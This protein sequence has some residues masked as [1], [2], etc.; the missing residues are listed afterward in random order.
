MALRWEGKRARTA[1]RARP[2]HLLLRAVSYQIRQNIVAGPMRP[3][4]WEDD[5]H[6]LFVLGL[7]M[8][9]HS[10]RDVATTFVRTRTPRQIERHYRNYIRKH[11][12][13][14]RNA[15]I[16]RALQVLQQARIPVPQ[17]YINF[18]TEREE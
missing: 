8:Y 9:G 18:L 17:A 2:W 1:R 3:G 5:E 10:W 14:Y 13:D 4:Q 16:P 12:E 7:H 11:N 15:E 6:R